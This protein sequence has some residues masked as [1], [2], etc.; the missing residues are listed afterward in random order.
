MK[1]IE[2]QTGAKL[3][4]FPMGQPCLCNGGWADNIS[5]AVEIWIMRKLKVNFY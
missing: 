1:W 3:V 5:L 4:F 2:T